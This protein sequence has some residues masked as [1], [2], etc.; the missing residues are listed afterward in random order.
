MISYGLAQ[1]DP[2]KLRPLYQQNISLNYYSI[3]ACLALSEK[4]D[5]IGLTLTVKYDEETE[6]ISHFIIQLT[7]EERR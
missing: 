4:I 1:S 3:S 5:K 2:T 7:T 6:P